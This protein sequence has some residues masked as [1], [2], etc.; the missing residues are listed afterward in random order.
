M[1]N[2]IWSLSKRRQTAENIESQRKEALDFAKNQVNDIFPN[3]LQDIE[4][5]VFE[6]TL[7]AYEADR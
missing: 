2:R 3:H 5:G 1:E 7:K 6:S 4:S